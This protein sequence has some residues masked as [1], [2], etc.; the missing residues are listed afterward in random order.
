M[1]VNAN[2]RKNLA[3]KVS[4]RITFPACHQHSPHF[5]AAFLF[6]FTLKPKLSQS[7]TFLHRRLRWSAQR[8]A[9]KKR[10]KILFLYSL[11]LRDSKLRYVIVNV[12]LGNFSGLCVIFSP[13]LQIEIC[14]SGEIYACT[15]TAYRRRRHLMHHTL[16]GEMNNDTADYGC[17]A[18]R[19]TDICIMYD[20]KIP[21]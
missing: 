19:F 5:P 1:P 6:I 15:S 8:K 7:I 9:G 21:K 3:R 4:A 16:R 2:I 18:I 11:L 12:A 20:S 17:Q 10:G 14:C 13:Q